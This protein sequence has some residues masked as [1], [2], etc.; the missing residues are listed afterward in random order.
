MLIRENHS[1]NGRVARMGQTRWHVCPT[2]F[3]VCNVSMLVSRI[4]LSLSPWKWLF[5]CINRA[6]KGKTRAKL[7]AWWFGWDCWMIHCKQI[8][9]YCSLLQKTCLAAELREQMTIKI[10]HA[11]GLLGNPVL[12]RFGVSVS[13]DPIITSARILEAPELVYRVEDR[14]V[15]V[16]PK[17]GQ[18]K[19]NKEEFIQATWRYVGSAYN[20][21][22]N[23][24]GAE[25]KTWSLISFHQQQLQPKLEWE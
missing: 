15:N 11:S 19:L 9:Y 14:L 22:P 16:R 6:A 7:I 20:I 13:H 21:N 12:H 23:F 17:D 2:G 18:W 8:S 3:L 5:S 4:K 25:V 10:L 24:K 1:S